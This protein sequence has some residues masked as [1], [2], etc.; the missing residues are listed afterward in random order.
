MTAA[1]N[2][3]LA[4]DTLESIRNDCPALRTVFL[5]DDAW[6]PFR[7]WHQQDDKVA[8][9][10]STLLLALERGHL[11]RLTSSIH[12]YLLH[13]DVL[14]PDVRRQYVKDLPELWMYHPNA[15]ERHHR[16][17]RHSGRIAELQC[18][19]WLETRGWTVAGLEAL[20]PGPD[21]EAKS[22]L[23]IITAFELKFIGSQD[24]D[25][26]MIVR[27]MAEGPSAYTVSPYAAINYL[28]FRIYEA[29]KQLVQYN[30]HKI[31]VAVIEDLTWSRFQ[32]Q[33]KNRWIDWRK[34]DFLPGD[35]EWQ[36]FMDQQKKP[37][38][39]TELRQ[40]LGRLDAAWVI[41]RTYGY[42]YQL[43]YEFHTHIQ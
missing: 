3:G 19:E 22:E 32:L 16:S 23:G 20:R 29:A 39:N 25:F 6:A 35:P 42:E 13:K 43:V 1:V 12:R 24:I 21:I 7:A 18:A 9:H 15:I 26:S 34:P 4:I 36:T 28:L 38:L 33:L 14:R 2:D 8:R 30:G 27:S 10:R 17:R 5:P 37:S 40:V 41:R 11:G 31:A